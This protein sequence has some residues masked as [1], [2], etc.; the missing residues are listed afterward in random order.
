MQWV[1]HNAEESDSLKA[2]VRRDGK[3]VPLTLTLDKG[4]RQR[5]PISFR[6]TTWELR[7]MVTGGLVLEDLPDDERLGPRPGPEAPDHGG[8][9]ED[10][11]EGVRADPS[12]GDHPGDDGDGD[13]GRDGPVRPV[14]PR[15]ARRPL[16]HPTPPAGQATVTG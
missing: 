6:T 2:E 9:G 15:R 3:V 1:L 11:R 10:G 5:Q 4:W 12:I 13:A 8:H 14:A 7:R 16:T